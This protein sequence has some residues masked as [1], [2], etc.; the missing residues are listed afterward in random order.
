MNVQKIYFC[1]H[2]KIDCV[3]IVIVFQSLAGQGLWIW[4]PAQKKGRC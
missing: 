1:E 4:I 3:I 2:V